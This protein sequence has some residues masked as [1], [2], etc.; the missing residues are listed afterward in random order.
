MFRGV[1]M[2]CRFHKNDCTVD[3]KNDSAVKQSIH[4]AFFQLIQNFNGSFSATPTT[5]RTEISDEST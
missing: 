3:I 1:A 5:I 2:K 4:K